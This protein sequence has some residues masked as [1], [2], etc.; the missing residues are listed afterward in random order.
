MS[1]D[2]FYK[3]FDLE[4]VIYSPFDNWHG[5][6]LNSAEEFDWSVFK[7]S[8]GS[9]SDQELRSS[10]HGLLAHIFIHHLCFYLT[11]QVGYKK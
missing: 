6:A 1:L 2:C 8:V 3:T 5:K 10:D 4:N 9:K 11:R 7:H